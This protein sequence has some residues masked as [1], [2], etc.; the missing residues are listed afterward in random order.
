MSAIFISHATPD[1]HLASAL[2]RGLQERGFTSSFLAFDPAA[3]VEKGALWEEKLYA[4]LDTCRVVL[5]ICTQSF[6][7]SHWC[8]AEI[9]RARAGRKRVIPLSDGAAHAIPSILSDT[10]ACQWS[11]GSTQGW[12]VLCNALRRELRDEAYLFEIKEGRTP[13]PGLFSFEA[14]DAAVFFGRE[15]EVNECF[16]RLEES[17]AARCALT[18]ALVGA[19]GSGKS[20][21]L[22]A[23][24]VARMRHTPDQWHVLGPY[25]VGQR[26]FPHVL[27]DIEAEIGLL[28]DQRVHQGKA[29]EA[30]SVADVQASLLP[31]LRALTRKLGRRRLILAIDQLEQ[32][33]SAPRVEPV[34]REEFDLDREAACWIGLLRA[35]QVTEAVDD[36]P[37]PAILCAL[38]T[39]FV[40][41]LQLLIWTGSA[42]SSAPAEQVLQSVRTTWIKPLQGA[43]L[44][45]VIRKPAERFGLRLVDHQVRALAEEAGDGRALP[46]LAYTL[47]RIWNIYGDDSKGWER[48]L[49]RAGL[50]NYFKA[51]ISELGNDIMSK[52][53]GEQALTRLCLKLV[54]M[55]D[56][57][58]IRQIVD[59]AQL[60][61]PERLILERL[62]N[63][64]VLMEDGQTVEVAHE[65]L[66]TDWDWLRNCI[67]T[68]T[69]FLQWRESVSHLHKVWCDHDES[70]RGLLSDPLMDDASRFDADLDLLAADVKQ[71]VE[72]SVRSRE[73]RQSRAKLLFV[74][75]SVFLS[76]VGLVIGALW[77]ALYLKN[78]TIKRQDKHSTLIELSARSAALLDT[79]PQLALSLATHSL[80]LTRLIPDTDK[81]P[82]EVRA[83]MSALYRALNEH[84]VR[85]SHV[86]RAGP[87]VTEVAWDPTSDVI[88]A[89]RVDGTVVLRTRRGTQAR[90]LKGASTEGAVSGLALASGAS[91]II[92]GH[93]NG[94]LAVW[95]TADG[96]RQCARRIA[97][98]VDAVSV[99]SQTVM[100]AIPRTIFVFHSE[101]GLCHALE[102]AQQVREAKMSIRLPDAVPNVKYLAFVEGAATRTVAAT[103]NGAVLI[104]EGAR[105][106]THTPAIND[107][108]ATALA[109]SGRRFAALTLNRGVMVLHL[110]SCWSSGCRA[111]YFTPTFV[112]GA[113]IKSI[114]FAPRSDE[115]LLATTTGEIYRNSKSGAGLVAR[116]PEKI[117][118]FRSD[119]RITRIITTSPNGRV[120][121]AKPQKQTLQR[122]EARFGKRELSQLVRMGA[123]GLR[124]AIVTN[125]FFKRG[126]DAVRVRRLHLYS[127][128]SA[129]YSEPT[130][131][132]ID[133]DR[134]A[135][136]LGDVWQM[137]L[138]N[139]DSVVGVLDEGCQ[140][141]FWTLID[142]QWRR[143]TD[144][145]AAALE[146]S[147]IEAVVARGSTPAGSRREDLCRKVDPQQ[148]TD[149][150]EGPRG[151]VFR[152]GYS[153]GAAQTLLLVP[154]RGDVLRIQWSGTVIEL[155]DASGQT[156]R[157]PLW[158]V[159][160][161]QKGVW[162]VKVD[163]S[164]S[165]STAVAAFSDGTVRAYDVGTI[166]WLSRACE[167]AESILLDDDGWKKHVR[168]LDRFPIC[169]EAVDATEKTKDALP[170]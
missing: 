88:A 10:Q 24:L 94:T 65:A 80:A 169:P 36:R 85:F 106:Q 49:K 33:A 152:D 37:A 92:A 44:V 133:L 109:P 32:L 35:C 25:R 71:Y 27:H 149:P 46:W 23:G 122:W 47:E 138:L 99:A 57:G 56:K 100:V 81:D 163:L 143:A 164:E 26:S 105:L 73:R 119:E 162:A 38:R 83:A 101:S 40:D 139:K 50:R 14:D 66:F 61:Q 131:S 140:V 116:L 91:Q 142:D 69:A 7:D 129:S 9:A 74:S 135:A 165:G 59:K 117:E 144:A 84:R 102:S 159:P 147:L 20:S 68:R 4:E 112:N 150:P 67:D 158:S 104:Y 58:P 29:G 76:I 39:D 114:A 8:F 154:R 42:I 157:E 161:C 30:V 19:S 126:D 43:M 124:A 167:I 34:G 82:D 48:E 16:L 110:D 22:R 155:M 141:A 17:R 78:E 118:S 93:S 128:L 75:A 18:L 123:E 145:E 62:V 146:G 111:E 89:G 103:R 28:V 132:T 151:D 170:M 136:Y 96:R 121:I 55:T 79:Q 51:T 5:A 15:V 107:A 127:D 115:L 60:P 95:S 156:L 77:V 31:A 1:C 90:V 120:M 137:E 64:R 168:R 54:R 97:G 148:R 98:V 21:V 70:E 13:Y 87:V 53:G 45:D 108:I 130:A 2:R 113:T 134:D 72:R 11:P 63:A 52:P 41:Q 3:G 125:E 166:S 12:D 86:M 153:C 6:A 160:S